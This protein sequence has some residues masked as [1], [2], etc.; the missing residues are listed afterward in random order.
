MNLNCKLPFGQLHHRNPVIIQVAQRLNRTPDSLAMKLCNFAS[1][2]PIHQARGVKGLPGASQADR[3]IW[4]DFHENWEEL[5]VY[6]EQLIEKLFVSDDEDAIDFSSQGVKVKTSKIIQAPSGPTEKTVLTRMRRGQQFFRE[7]ILNSYG[8]RCCITAIPVRELLIASHILPW[9]K[10]PKER[11]NPQNGLCLSTLHDAAFDSGLI[12]FDNKF[13]LILS[14]ELKGYLPQPILE[15]NFAAYEGIP[16]RFPEMLS[17][18]NLEFLKYHQKEIF[19]RY[20][21]GVGIS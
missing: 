9:S 17:T 20:G 12:T 6:S 14:K 11:L 4:K 7:T 21:F 15:R 8:N 5:G 18:P 16:I 19:R 10:F 13:R 3:R 1:L 2:D